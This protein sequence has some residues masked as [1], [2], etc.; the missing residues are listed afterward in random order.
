LSV[1]A[2]GN[3]YNM[4]WYVAWSSIPSNGQLVGGIY[5][6]PHNSSRWTESWLLC[7]WAHWPRQSTIDVCSSQLLDQIVVQTADAHRT[8]RCYS[9][10]SPLLGALC[11]DRPLHE[12]IHRFF[13]ASFVFESWTFTPLLDLILNTNTSKHMT[14]CILSAL[15]QSS[16]HYAN[17]KH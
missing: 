10:E 17:Y 15:V 4:C 7:H 8:V 2:L 11:A 12:F 3:V 13:W 5:N 9:S 1:W 14:C 16:L 6:L